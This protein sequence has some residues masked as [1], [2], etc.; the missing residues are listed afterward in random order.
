MKQFFLATLAVFLITAT[1]WAG[2]YD[3]EFATTLANDTFGDVVREAGM[4]AAYRGV[5]PAEPQG[6]TGFD[7]GL[8][9]NVVDIDTSKWD[10]VIDAGDSSAP[11]YLPVPRIHVR[12]GLPFNFDVGAMYAKAPSSNI[13]LF[14]AEIQW[15]L[16]EGSVA[17]PALALRGSYSTLNGV[18]DLDLKTY[19][20]DVVLSKG[21][22]MLTPY[23]G[24]GLV[25]I[26]G[27]YAGDNPT[28]QG[29]LD[30]HDFTETRIFGGFQASLALLRIT[31]DVEYSRLPVY[32]AKFSL[33]W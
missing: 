22:A 24:A 4:V 14:G 7:I 13:E 11:S 1:A 21:F 19:A 33:G 2:K 31:L 5:A 18:D 8:E 15:A 20:G 6:I 26:E 16:L 3:I 25:K 23:I 29:I 17:T 28:L 32:T 30:D 12:K 9:F 10:D 27:E